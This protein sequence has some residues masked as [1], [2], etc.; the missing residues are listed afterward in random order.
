M[1][2]PSRLSGPTRHCGL[3]SWSSAPQPVHY[4]AAT[5][6]PRPLPTM[7]CPEHPRPLNAIRP[8]F[9]L[10]SLLSWL[11][12]FSPWH[13]VTCPTRPSSDMISV[14][15]NPTPQSTVSSLFQVAM[16]PGKGSPSES[17]LPRDLF[18]SLLFQQDGQAL[19]GGV[20]PYSFLAQW[21]V[22]RYA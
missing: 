5:L 12:C 16:V 3:I 4:I 10:F 18:T 2:Y 9:M 11:P 15:L 7:P 14:K 20:I 22:H 1:L 6:A 13:V 21:Q 17:L 8:L 19:K